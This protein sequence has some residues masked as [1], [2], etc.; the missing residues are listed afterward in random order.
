M[1]LLIRIK[2]VFTVVQRKIIQ[3][4]MYINT[5]TYMH[6]YVAF[7]KKQGMDISGMPNYISNDVHFD[8]KDYSI[9]HLGDGCTISREVHFLT[10]DYSM[11]TVLQGLETQLSENARKTLEA[12]DAR[13]KILDLRGIHVGDHTFIGARAQL[14]P[15][16]HLGNNCIVGGGTVVKGYYGDN[17]IL[18][19]NP[20]TVY[21]L[22]TVEWLERNANRIQEGEKKNG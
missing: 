5:G 8:G 4:S 6:K 15:G 9:I 7:L 14:L 22:S 12:A 11:H 17:T 3:L 21:H 2:K 10:H 13:D 20:A 19:G 1:K 16:T 18:I